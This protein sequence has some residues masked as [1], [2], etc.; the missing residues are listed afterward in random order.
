MFAKTPIY[1][2]SIAKKESQKKK[3]RSKDSM[4]KAE[5]LVKINTES[6][7]ESDKLIGISKKHL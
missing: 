2:I 4:I 3:C 6:L 1:D 5:M 7:V